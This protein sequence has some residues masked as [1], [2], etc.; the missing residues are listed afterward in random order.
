MSTRRLPLAAALLALALLVAVATGCSASIGSSG[1]DTEVVAYDNTDYGFSL[2]HQKR[3]A[4]TSDTSYNATAGASAAFSIGFVDPDGAM[5]GDTG[6]DGI[7]VS[8]YELP[9]TIKPAQVP[10]L[11]GV[12]EGVVTQLQKGQ[13]DGVFQPLE[14][15]TINGTPGFKL[16]YT[17]P[18][19]SE[20]L[21]ADTYFLVK[22][23]KEYQLTVQSAKENWDANRPALQQSVDSFTVK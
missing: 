8:V 14:D 21:V 3:F 20:T 1:N 15:V 23:D 17:M 9:R 12:L 10:Q 13:P 11:R 6:L 19:G 18:S 22:G 4:E 2:E 7:L 5:S 16:S